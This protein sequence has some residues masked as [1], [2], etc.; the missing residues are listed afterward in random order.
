ME[1]QGTA[2]ASPVPPYKP[3][4]PHLSESPLSPNLILHR[5][6]KNPDT[7]CMLQNLSDS[8]QHRISN[9]THMKP[10]FSDSVLE[11]MEVSNTVVP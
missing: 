5:K 10:S 2:L 6:K 7:M 4:Q 3:S 1:R 9:A 8:H 11:G